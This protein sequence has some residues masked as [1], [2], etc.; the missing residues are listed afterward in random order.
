MIKG[1]PQDIFLASHQPKINTR[2]FLM[3]GTTQEVSLQ[4]SGFKN[5]LDSKSIPLKGASGTEQ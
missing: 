2:S 3:L 1:S 5:C 4:C